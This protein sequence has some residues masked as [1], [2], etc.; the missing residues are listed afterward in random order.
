MERFDL[1]DLL[2]M[3]LEQELMNF[4]QR[5]IQEYTPEQ[6]TKKA[7]EIAVKEQIKD[8]IINKDLSEYQIRALLKSDGIIDEV[9]DEWLSEDSRLGEV[10]ENSIDTTLD[11]IEANFSKVKSNR[12]RER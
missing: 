2:T 10:L 3:K 1:R 6:I 12:E 5:I 11:I 7:Y 9:Y 8:E 4:T